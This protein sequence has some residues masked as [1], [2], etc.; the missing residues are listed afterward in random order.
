LFPFFFDC[1]VTYDGIIRSR[2]DDALAFGIAYGSYSGDLRSV[3]RQARSKGLLGPYGDR[4][5]D[6]EMVLE[7]NYWWQI[8]KWFVVTPDIQYII[9]PKGYSNIENALVLGAQVGVTF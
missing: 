5:Q 8:T 3:Q 1:G 6:F 7:L 2:P 4:P 9:H